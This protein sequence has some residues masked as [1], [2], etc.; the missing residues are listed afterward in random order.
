[1]GLRILIVDDEPDVRDVLREYLHTRGHD[2]TALSSGRE[3]L[4]GLRDSLHGDDRGIGHLDVA[5]VDWHM[6]GISGRDVIE[7]LRVSRPETEIIVSTGEISEALRGI[8]SDQILRKP[9]SLRALARRL[10]ALRPA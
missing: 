2:V 7:A 6:P 5:L 1:M 9:F 10:D 8:S 3:V 4:D